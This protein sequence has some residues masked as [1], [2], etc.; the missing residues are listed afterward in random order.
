MCSRMLSYGI[1]LF[2]YASTLSVFRFIVT[3]LPIC[4][5]VNSLYLLHSLNPGLHHYFPLAKLINPEEECKQS[6]INALFH[7]AIFQP[8][9]NSLRQF[10]ISYPIFTTLRAFDKCLERVGVWSQTATATNPRCF[11]VVRVSAHWRASCGTS[12]L[13]TLKKQTLRECYDFMSFPKAS[14]LSK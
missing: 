9:E 2:L 11:P 5:H 14:V 12:P 10:S 7:S 13:S 6:C 8:G 3:E 1:T 4:L